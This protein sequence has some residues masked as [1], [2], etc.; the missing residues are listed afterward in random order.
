MN[1]NQRKCS[2]LKITKL[3]ANQRCPCWNCS[4]EDQS[5][6]SVLKRDNCSCW[7]CRQKQHVLKVSSKIAR[8]ENDGMSFSAHNGIL[9]HD[10]YSHLWLDGW[11]ASC[12]S[13]S[14]ASEWV[15]THQTGCCVCWAEYTTGHTHWANSISIYDQWPPVKQASCKVCGWHNSV[16]IVWGPRS[17]LWDGGYCSGDWSLVS[18]QQYCAEWGQD[19]RDGWFTLAALVQTLPLYW[20]TT[21]LWNRSLAS[22]FSGAPLTTSSHGKIMLTTST[23]RPAGGCTFCAYSEG[24]GLSHTTLSESS[25]LQFAP[26]WNVHVRPGTAASLGNSR[27]RLNPFNGGLCAL[28]PQIC[29]TGKRWQTSACPRWRRGERGWLGAF[30]LKLLETLIINCATSSH[31]RELSSMAFEQLSVTKTQR[32]IHR[33]N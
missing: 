13:A 33:Q 30:S 4:R 23:P 16:G 18:R 26:F 7:K 28:L 14:S 29:H 11:Q 22:N 9:G 24:P 6:G 2:V 3:S 20:S 1:S 25:P 12:V 17:H 8:A 32:T 5:D 10:P 19:Q 21:L 27:K 15:V 31:M